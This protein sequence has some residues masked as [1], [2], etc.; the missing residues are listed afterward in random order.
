M[1]YTFAAAEA[2]GACV[3]DGTHMLFVGRQ[4]VA[5][6]L[7]VQPAGSLCLAASV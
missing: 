4:P 2:H 1:P 6:L 7:M 5:V 3:T